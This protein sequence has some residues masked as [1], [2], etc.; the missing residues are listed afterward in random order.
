MTGC[1]AASVG[2]YRQRLSVRFEPMVVVPPLGAI[3]RCTQWEAEGRGRATSAGAHSYLTRG[4]RSVGRGGG[5]RARVRRSVR[6]PYRISVR[7]APR[8]C[9]GVCTAAADR[10][11][12]GWA[13]SYKIEEIS[14]VPLSPSAPRHALAPR[15]CVSLITD[16]RPPMGEPPPANIS[17]TRHTRVRIRNIREPLRV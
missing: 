10:G 14:L 17:P 16:I 15:A 1:V 4:G 9:A 11:G 8:A 6:R 13:K 5:G 12:M 3:A 7:S 2:R